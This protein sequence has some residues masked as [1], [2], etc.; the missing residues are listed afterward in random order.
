M[1]PKGGGG[2]GG[3]GHGGGGHGG[4]RSGGG[5][6]VGAAGGGGHSGAGALGPDRAVLMLVLLPMLGFLFQEMDAGEVAKWVMGRGKGVMQQ[7]LT[8]SMRRESNAGR[9]EEVASG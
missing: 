2:G 4:G 9:V 3:G 8:T 5:R 6:A 7:L 1:A